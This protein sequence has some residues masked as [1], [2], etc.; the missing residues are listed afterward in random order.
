MRTG[1][2]RNRPVVGP[3]PR[4]RLW[5]SFTWRQ[6]DGDGSFASSTMCASARERLMASAEYAGSWPVIVM[7]FST[8]SSV[9]PAL[10]V[11]P[12]M[13]FDSAICS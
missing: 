1:P 9:S 5:S 12:S 3:P 8:A 7:P 4:I 10:S 13:A 6:S 11:L 2:E